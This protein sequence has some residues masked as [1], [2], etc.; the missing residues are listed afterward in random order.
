[1]AK[2][3]LKFKKSPRY[4]HKR[5]E[6][7]TRRGAARQARLMTGPVSS[8]ESLDRKIRHILLNVTRENILDETREL[9]R[10]GFGAAASFSMLTKVLDRR[11]E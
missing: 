11:G 8:G 7:L 6:G 3:R 10:L 4:P 1:M 2:P 9:M 5:S